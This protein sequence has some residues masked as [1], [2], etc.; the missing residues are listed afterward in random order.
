MLCDHDWLILPRY[1]QALHLQ[2]HSI[3]TLNQGRQVSV[4]PTLG[5][6]PQGTWPRLVTSLSWRVVG[7]KYPSV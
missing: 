3:T 5:N 7:P 6:M 2:A 4:E 1:P